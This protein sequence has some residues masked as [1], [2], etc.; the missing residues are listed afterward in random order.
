MRP[1]HPAIKDR[2]NAVRAKIRNAKDE[3]GLF[4]NPRTAAWCHK[5]LSTVQL[6]EGSSFQEDDRNQYQHITTAIGYFVDWHWPAG[7]SQGGNGKLTGN[8]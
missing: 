8:Y 6:K 4:V 7:R 5:G 2:Q 1:A 3:I